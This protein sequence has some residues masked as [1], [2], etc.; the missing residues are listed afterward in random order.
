MLN[1]LNKRNSSENYTEMPI[2]THQMAVTQKL[3]M[4]MWGKGLLIHLCCNCKITVSKEG[5][6]VKSNKAT[7]SLTL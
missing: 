6:L 2:L 5:N 3:D 7:Y 4:A 1:F